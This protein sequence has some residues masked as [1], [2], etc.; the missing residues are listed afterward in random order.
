MPQPASARRQYIWS[1]ALSTR[2]VREAQKARKSGSRAV[3]QVVIAHQAT[4]AF[5]A[6]AAVAQMLA[7]QRIEE[8]AQALLVSP[9]FTTEIAT[10][11]KMLEE[12]TLEFEFNRLV[13]SLVQDAGRA[14]EQAATAV[15]PNVGFVRFLSPPSCSRCAVLAGRVYRY[16]QGFLRHPGCDC[17]MVPTTLANPAFV[18]D[19]VELMREGQVTGLSKA[20][21]KA[22]GDGADFG[23]VV[24]VRRRAAGLT[25]AGEILTRAGR[26]TPAAIYKAAT[27]RDNAIERLT[28]AGYVR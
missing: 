16:S 3:A 25:E 4:A 14:A 24:N 11:E 20:D 5:Q 26:P 9:A 12:T 23:K 8:S 19:P 2:A 15:T 7:E 13:E 22:I 18:V 17:I 27:S 6:P 28:A 10:L 1:V 21:Q